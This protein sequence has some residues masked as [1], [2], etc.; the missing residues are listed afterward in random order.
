MFN[1]KK[2]LTIIFISNISSCNILTTDS[3]LNKTNFDNPKQ[4]SIKKETNKYIV[5]FGNKNTNSNATFT[6]KVNIKKN[7]FNIKC[8]PGP[9]PLGNCTPIDVKSMKVWLIEYPDAGGYP[10]P[11]ATVLTPVAGTSFIFDLTMNP[12]ASIIYQNVP[13]NMA[14]HSYAI[15]AAPFDALAGGG[16]NITNTSTGNAVIVNDAGFN[17]AYASDSGGD[18]L[19]LGSVKVNASHVVSSTNDLQISMKVSP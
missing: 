16:N 15:A 11:A 7:P 14:S 6:F 9:L 8:T 17:F 3:N 1:L 19:N 12:N 2:L 18:P 13:A 5:D 4:I 10:I